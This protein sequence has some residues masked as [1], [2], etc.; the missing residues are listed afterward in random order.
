MNGRVAQLGESADPDVDA[1][2]LDGTPLRTVT[3]RTYLALH[4]PVGFVTSLRSTHGEPLVSEL[5]DLP[6]R[7]FPVGRLDKETS[8]LLLLTDD[9]GWSNLVT[10]PRYRVEKEYVLTVRAVPDEEALER[11]RRGV[12]LP[13]G[14]RTAPARVRPLR[15]VEGHTDLSVTVIEGKKRQI[16]LMAAAIGHPALSL[17]RIRI[18]QIRLGALPVGRYRALE[19]AEIASIGAHER[20]AAEGRSP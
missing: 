19:P 8:G 4:K 1:I 7:V 20:R 16:R 5:I 3:A 9:G 6:A 14:S 11:L 17:T 13:D 10:H 2:V 15:T 18:G 12:L